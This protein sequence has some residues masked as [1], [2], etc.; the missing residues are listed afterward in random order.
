M[1]Q[2]KNNRLLLILLVIVTLLIVALE[3]YERLGTPK[4]R[5]NLTG[6]NIEKITRIAVSDAKTGQYL[7]LRKEEIGWFITADKI[8]I[9]IENS[10]IEKILILMKDMKPVK[11]V[12][13]D[14]ED[15]ATYETSDESGLRI[16][17]YNVK[18]ILTDFFIGKV[19]V[20]EETGL[21]TTYVRVQKD[22]DI[23]A[24]KGDMKAVFTQDFFEQ[25]F[26]AE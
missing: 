25:I 23:Y 16:T 8:Q 21:Q 19:E 14:R 5:E 10:S 9:P 12:S 4:N 1:K 6:L 3:V 13:S 22:D 20:N 2:K 11:K 15:W 24:V 7:S 17:A 26:P 18:D